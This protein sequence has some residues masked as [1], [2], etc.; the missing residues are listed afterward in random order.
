MAH[1]GLAR[2]VGMIAAGIWGELQKLPVN[3][4]RKANPCKLSWAPSSKPP[5]GLVLGVLSLSHLASCRSG[6]S[7][8]VGFCGANRRLRPRPQQ[9]VHTIQMYVF[10][11]SNGPGAEPPKGTLSGGSPWAV[12]HTF[13]STYSCRPPAWRQVIAWQIRERQ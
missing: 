7:V 10:V 2:W 5:T 6:V 12:L 13:G 11:P 8:G 4:K 3:A 1:D 9:V